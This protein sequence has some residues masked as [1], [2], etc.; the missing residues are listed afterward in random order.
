MKILFNHLI[1]INFKSILFVIAVISTG[2]VLAN[3]TGG[4]VVHGN[5]SFNHPNANTLNVTN[6]PN[7]IINWQQF[8]VNRD[9]ITRFIQQSPNS[10]VLNRIVGQ[11]PS[12]I[13]GQ[14]RSNGKVFIINP[15][16]IIFGRHS[17]VNTAG[18]IASTLN[19]SNRDFLNGRLHFADLEN[20]A[21]ILNQGFIH[22]S[23][24]GEVVMVAPNIKNEGVINVEN[25]HLVLAAGQSVTLSSLGYEDIEFEVQAPENSVVN[26][27]DLISD[28]GSIGVFA[29]NIKHSGRAS[30]NAIEMDDAGNIRFVAKKDT[31]INNGSIS[32]SSEKGKAG[33][34]ELLG[35]RVG[36]FGKSTVTASAP[37]GGG[38]I[39]VGGDYQGKGKTKTAKTTQVASDVEIHAD[40][41][42]N[43]I[44]SK[45]NG[46]KVI[47]WS[48][49]YTRFA[50]TVTAK[51]GVLGGD[52]GFIEISGKDKLNFSGSADTA[53]SHGRAGTVLFDPRNI[54]ISTTGPAFTINTTNNTFAATPATDAIFTNTSIANLLVTQNVLL[55][56][57]NDIFIDAGAN[58]N[59]VGGPG[60]ALTLQAG[61]S[62][63]IRAN[64]NTNGGALTL[65]ANS[66]L[67]DG[68][69]DAQRAPGAANISIGDGTQPIAINTA[70]GN[71]LMDIRGGTGLTNSTAGAVN[72]NL[73]AS[74]NAGSGLLTFDAGFVNNSGFIALLN[75]MD[76]KNV[77]VFTN[78][79]DGG[80]DFQADIGITNTI[81]SAN[82]DNFGFIRK[83]AGVQTSTI[84]P[85]LNN[86]PNSAVN[87]DSGSLSLGGAPLILNKSVLAGVGTFVG[88]VISKGGVVDT[89]SDSTGAIGTLTINGNLTLDASSLTVFDLTGNATQGSTYD[90]LHVTGNTVLDG[91]L[92]VLWNFGLTTSAGL[93]NG[94]TLNLLQTD[95]A[96]TG[97]FSSSILPVGVIAP[98]VNFNT[99]NIAQ[100]AITSV[101]PN[102]KFW[103]PSTGGNWNVGANWSGGVVPTSTDFAVVNQSNTNT[104][105]VTDVRT[106][107]GVEIG[108]SLT[109]SG[110]G[111]L[112]L[113]GDSTIAGDFFTLAGTGGVFSDANLF[114]A[115]DA[116]WI[117]GSLGGA[118]SMTL[119]GPASLN[120]G[121]DVT[122]SVANFTNEGLINQ[123]IGIL[124]LNHSGK[125][126]FTNNG[127]MNVAAISNNSSDLTLNG[128]F[129]LG[130]L[131]NTG[132][133]FFNN[134]V[135]VGR[136]NNVGNLAIFGQLSA[137]DVNNDGNMRVAGLS[138]ISGLFVQNSA[139]AVT[140][141][142]SAVMAGQINNMAG[143]LTFNGNVSSSAINN[144]GQLIFNSG[145]LPAGSTGS[146]TGGNT[147]TPLL[148]QF[149]NGN[150]DLVIT[151]SV[152][153]NINN[154][155]TMSGN[156]DIN[157]NVTNNG[158]LNVGEA[159]FPGAL[160]INGDLVLL[161]NSVLVFD[162][163]GLQ[164]LTGY[165]ALDVT[166]NIALNGIIKLAVNPDAYN[167]S[168][169]SFNDLFTPLKYASHTGS[170]TLASTTGYNFAIVVGDTGI[171]LK[172]KT[173]PGLIDKLESLKQKQSDQISDSI[174]FDDSV[175]TFSKVKKILLRPLKKKA[176]KDDD[177][178]E[179]GQT[180]SCS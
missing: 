18:L 89:G 105:T 20:N 129:N 31:V 145:G 94:S 135:S 67:A 4:S 73:L 77:T 88:N 22:T 180:L 85:V 7:A 171:E 58:I 111:S 178:K 47:L 170:A 156:V 154:N 110:I 78:A 146:G 131:N 117:S 12:Q 23:K 164:V 149:I 62:I 119:L 125:S 30:V 98:V 49:E 134:D 106:V 172:T 159:G 130:D 65:I 74:V 33:K 81:G 70:G 19:I 163:A 29:G 101:S 44:S 38:E 127:S 150:G 153:A 51:G 100:L 76:L 118:G 17:T 161:Q 124:T 176:K 63:D 42:N 140:L 61:R 46:G 144:D 25:G 109:L 169:A 27:G 68:V 21:A 57:S 13:L 133:L 43:G 90:F 141:F 121:G 158:V 122:L 66:N 126:T 104:V 128:L 26:L 107:Q 102:I 95:G 10:A 148:A 96:F 167:S 113:T 1:K 92:V 16:G 173:I 179:E 2:V 91:R 32:A 136:L 157:G 147:N 93:A 3:P 138:S 137:T 71:I 139:S 37:T 50:G 162:I 54:H 175:T 123:N 6:S 55:Q 160:R 165:D 168:N 48:D 59:V 35:E 8:G 155:G 86:E 60:M 132:N 152:N 45:G 112:T 56:A 14:L 114:I 52:G 166:G 103:L 108:D 9:E 75:N 53:A 80:I 79:V 174:I 40:A 5:V 151:N 83:S 28:G 115:S 177:E 36:L 24:N 99:P 64:V 97:A 120:I 69:V 143:S 82:I 34:V 116:L 39:L 41:T 84:I 72:I 142:D 87:I 11:N 15:N